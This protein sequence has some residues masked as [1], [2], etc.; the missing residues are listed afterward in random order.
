MKTPLNVWLIGVVAL[1][2]AMPACAGPGGGG[3][4][5]RRFAEAGGMPVFSRQPMDR[6]MRAQ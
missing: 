5:G 3:G 4:H 2:A 1:L 6:P